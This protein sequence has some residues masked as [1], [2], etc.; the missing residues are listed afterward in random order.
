M[1]ASA[2]GIERLR[3]APTVATRISQ[4]SVI[5]CRRSNRRVRRA[6]VLPED[7]DDLESQLIEIQKIE[8]DGPELRDELRR[9]AVPFQPVRAG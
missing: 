1:S 4:S 6:V 7:L 5:D 3:A 8:I 2:A 9:R